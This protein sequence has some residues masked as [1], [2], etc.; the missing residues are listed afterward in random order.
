MVHGKDR[1][2]VCPFEVGARLFL[3]PRFT[4]VFAIV[5]FE[6]TLP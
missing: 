2:Y 4:H 3:I 6:Q 1:M 5:L